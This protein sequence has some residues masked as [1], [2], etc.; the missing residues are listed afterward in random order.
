MYIWNYIDTRDANRKIPKLEIPRFSGFTNPES[1]DFLKLVP[2]FSGLWIYAV[3]TFMLNEIR[4][5]NCSLAKD[6]YKS[7]CKR[8]KEGRTVY[9]PLLNL[10][11]NP[12]KKS[13]FDK[14]LD[15]S[16]I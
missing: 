10:V 3:L 7:L 12:N 14:D 9:S 16:L 11:K 1:W 5:I 4:T 8:I 6:L 13:D 2:G 15:T